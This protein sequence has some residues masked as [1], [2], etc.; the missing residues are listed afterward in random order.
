MPQHSYAVLDVETTHGDPRKGSLLEIGVVVHD[1]ISEITR[2]NSLIRPTGSIPGFIRQLTGIGP[3]VVENA[4]RFAE[5]AQDLMHVTRDRIIVA[6]NV[7]YDMTALEYEFAR[8]GLVFQRSV[9]CTEQ[10]SRLLLPSLSY[11]NLTSLCRYFGIVFTGRHRALNDASATA[12]LH[13]RLIR[14]FG[15][16]RLLGS[17]RYWPMKASA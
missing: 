8:T 2:W 5:V 12:A 10:L 4:P 6:H 11:Y 1:G 13:Q 9:L 17:L 16:E 15:E 14:E 7:R 3:A